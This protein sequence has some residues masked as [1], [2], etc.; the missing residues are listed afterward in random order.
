MEL[1]PIKIIKAKEKR[2]IVERDTMR[3]IKSASCELDELLTC[4]RYIDK[5]GFF[6]NCVRL[7]VNNKFIHINRSSY[8]G[9]VSFEGSINY[10]NTKYPQTFS[11]KRIIQQLEKLLK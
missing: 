5:Y 10:G 9:R 1:K 4:L 2:F 11:D 3:G 8:S 6:P 7:T